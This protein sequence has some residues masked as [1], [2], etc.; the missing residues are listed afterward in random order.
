MTVTM[1]S[2]AWTAIGEPS[3]LMGAQ[4]CSTS[5][6]SAASPSWVA[7]RLATGWPADAWA[8][9]AEVWAGEPGA[10]RVGAAAASSAPA[11]LAPVG[12][13]G[14]LPGADAAGVLDADVV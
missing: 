4:P 11:W 1:S 5:T 10:G 6:I 7:R 12:A 13:V 14:A 2:P 8:G 3:M 9:E